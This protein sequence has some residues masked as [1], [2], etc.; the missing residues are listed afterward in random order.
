MHEELSRSIELSVIQFEISLSLSPKIFSPH[1][2][3]VVAIVFASTSEKLR[4]MYQNGN[5]YQRNCLR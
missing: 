3:L 4:V 5:Q 1:E 2:A